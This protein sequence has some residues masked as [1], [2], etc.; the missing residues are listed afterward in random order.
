[1]LIMKMLHIHTKI[2]ISLGR[3]MKFCREQDAKEFFA[4]LE[5]SG[6]YTFPNISDHRESVHIKFV[7][8]SHR[9]VTE[10]KFEAETEG[11]TIQ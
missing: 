7:K 5:T 11:K 10:T 9:K 1:M 6:H 8:D 4:L 2:I 3:R